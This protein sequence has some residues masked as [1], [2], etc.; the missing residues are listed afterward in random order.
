[1]GLKRAS[2]WAFCFIPY[3]HKILKRMGQGAAQCPKLYV[4]IIY[5]QK[6]GTPYSN[7][8]SGV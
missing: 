3:P 8:I 7:I 2:S 1:M 6:M 5:T 4:K